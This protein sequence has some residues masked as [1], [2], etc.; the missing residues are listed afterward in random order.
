[1]LLARCD[2]FPTP[3][4]W[5]GVAVLFWHVHVDDFNFALDDEEDITS[6]CALSDYVGEGVERAG[7]G[8][9]ANEV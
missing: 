1:M 7:L 4:V 3:G 5:R 8:A 9:H 6:L 2:G